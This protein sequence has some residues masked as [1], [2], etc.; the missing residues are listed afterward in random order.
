M[1]ASGNTSDVETQPIKF[2]S[3]TEKDQIKHDEKVDC[4]CPSLKKTS[5]SI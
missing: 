5:E 4:N 1:D 2:I 3:P